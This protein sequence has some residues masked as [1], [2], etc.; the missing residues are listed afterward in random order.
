LQVTKLAKLL[1]LVAVLVVGVG[2]AAAD[3]RAFPRERSVSADFVVA[4]KE[5]RGSVDKLLASLDVEPRYRFASKALQG[6][7]A[8]LT[9]RQMQRLL[10]DPDVNCVCGENWTWIVLY[11]NRRV[12]YPDMAARTSALVAKYGF[13]TTFRYYNG[14]AAQL[15]AGQLHGL[16][17]EP[18]IGLIEPDSYASWAGLRTHDAPGTPQAKW[19]ALGYSYTNEH[20][21]ANRID[22]ARTPAQTARWMSR[23]RSRDQYALKHLNHSRFGVLAIFTVPRVRFEVY[24]VLLVKGGLT[25]QIRRAD[26]GFP[27]PQYALIRIRKDSLPAPVKALYIDEPG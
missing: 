21:P 7:A 5:K 9:F 1:L 27:V 18:D 22:Y 16:T 20:H 8:R 13:T 17:T 10:K 3:R 25:A 15:S 23:L 2:P 4:L 11:D 26:I 6:F 12:A 24:A 19:K 14:F